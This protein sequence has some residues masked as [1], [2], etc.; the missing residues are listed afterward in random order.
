MKMLDSDI[1]QGRD[2]SLMNERTIG[3]MIVDMQEK[4]AYVWMLRENEKGWVEYSIDF[5]K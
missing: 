2:A 4:N 3:K 1:S 5:I